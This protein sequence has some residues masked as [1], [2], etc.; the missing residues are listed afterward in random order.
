MANKALNT[1]TRQHFVLTLYPPRIH[2]PADPGFK[3]LH[4][5]GL[6]YSS[7]STVLFVIVFNAPLRFKMP[8]YHLFYMLLNMNGK[9]NDHDIMLRDS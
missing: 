1:I 6:K 2:P 5:K 3:C 4:V 7:T 9:K 8:I